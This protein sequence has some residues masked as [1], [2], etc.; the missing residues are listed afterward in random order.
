MPSYA[1]EFIR[2]LAGI[3]I[4]SV[5]HKVRSI[6]ANS[7]HLLTRALGRLK[8]ECVRGA[9]RSRIR[10]QP[11]RCSHPYTKGAPRVHH[12]NELPITQASEATQQR[13][14]RTPSS[15]TQMLVVLFFLFYVYQKPRPMADPFLPIPKQ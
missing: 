13:P 14:C 5:R 15:Y 1:R 11:Y 8:H 6:L 12:E 10:V 7:D 9:P 2:K 4:V 3:F